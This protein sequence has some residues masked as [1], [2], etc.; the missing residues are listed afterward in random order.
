MSQHHPSDHDLERYHLDTLTGE[1][2]RA[3]EEHI[4]GCASC[5]GRALDIAEF[6]EA[7]RAGAIMGDFDL[8]L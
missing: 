6:V 3:L 1:E 4:I 2:L 7:M 8:H 5:V